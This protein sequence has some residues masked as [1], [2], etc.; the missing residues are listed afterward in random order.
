ME[1]LWPWVRKVMSPEET[2]A[3][4]MPSRLPE[5]FIEETLIP[6]MENCIR[7]NI[8]TY[9]PA[10]LT[11]LARG[12]ALY[13][14]RRDTSGNGPLMEYLAEMIKSRMVAFTAIEI[15]DI[16]PACQTLFPDDTELFDMLTE[17][18]KETI[19]DYS[20][21]NLIGLVRTFARRE[22]EKKETNQGYPVREILIPRL[23]EAMER[24]D[25]AEVCDI[26]VAIADS[27]ATDKTIN[28][29][30]PIM[31]CVLPEL[32]HRLDDLGE[33]IPLVSHISIAWALARLG[34]YHEEYLDRLAKI[35]HEKEHVRNDITPRY[36]VRLIWIYCKCDALEKIVDDI[37]PVLEASVAYM[38]SAQFARL[39]QCS[40][41]MGKVKDRVD[42]AKLVNR[43][44]SETIEKN[45]ERPEDADG[46]FVAWM[47][48]GSRLGR[49][50]AYIHKF[51][52][53][54]EAGEIQ[55]IIKVLQVAKKGEYR[56]YLDLLP[57]SWESQKK[58]MLHRIA[59]KR[60]VEE[61]FLL[62]EAKREKREKGFLKRV[63]GL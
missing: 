29:D 47:R 4:V 18:I 42:I 59:K 53:E 9:T 44:E 36:L 35:L 16:L 56:A 58:D 63:F 6:H 62:E 38:G 24:Y 3:L 28:M 17:R 51:Q 1:L 8:K 37:A 54:F 19:N 46:N 48:D 39:A 22:I 26:I 30:L 7:F 61:K 49:L 21:L 25:T 10:E 34:I 12:Y 5:D 55:K 15:V 27:A 60:E 23:K 14:Y 43:L 11:Q 2:K 50:L 52:D 41:Q 20:A 33:T 13:T 32:E 40:E 31:Q 57:A 45:V